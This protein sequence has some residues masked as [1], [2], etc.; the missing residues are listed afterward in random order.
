VWVV[1]EGGRVYGWGR[2]SSR[3]GELGLGTPHLIVKHPTLLTFSVPFRV[4]RVFSGPLCT[5]AVGGEAER[6]AYVWGSVY[7]EAPIV[8]PEKF[9]QVTPPYSIQQ[10]LAVP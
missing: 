1:V 6:E 10:V 9:I 4:K 3:G 5:C 2:Q 7:T 8:T